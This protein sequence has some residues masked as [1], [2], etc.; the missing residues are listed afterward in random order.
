MTERLSGIVLDTVKHNDRHNVVTLFTR[1]RG[2]VAFLS[3]AG[4]GKAA[5]MRNARLQPLSAIET[6]VNFVESRS[7]HILGSI[8]PI[9]IWRDIYFNPVKSAIAIFMTEFLNRYLRD[10][11]PDPTTWDFVLAAVRDLDC[12]SCSAANFHIAFL[13]RFLEFA[14]I[15]PELDNYEKGDFLDMQAGEPVA[16]RPI[17]HNYLS[18]EEAAFLPLLSRI[19]FANAHRF[20]LSADQRRLI[21]HRLLQYYASH[22]PWLSNLRSPAILSTLF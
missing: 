18:P 21:L 22:F 4:N 3:P 7:L 6:D 2:R 8:T 11:S 5:R 1:Q 19:N 10:S 16:Y 17:N 13:V 15:S 12:R 9:E 14:G 20:R